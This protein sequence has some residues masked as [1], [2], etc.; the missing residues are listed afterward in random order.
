MDARQRRVDVMTAQSAPATSHWTK[1]ASLSLCAH[2]IIIE[3]KKIATAI[4]MVTWGTCLSGISTAM[5]R[6]LPLPPARVN[7][8]R[9]TSPRVSKT[10]FPRTERTD[11]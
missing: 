1:V 4:A 6:G 5:G 10:T 8:R 9:R 2:S 3:T 7:R 11:A